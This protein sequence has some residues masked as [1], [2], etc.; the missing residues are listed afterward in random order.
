MQMDYGKKFTDQW[1]A[2]NSAAMASHWEYELDGYTPNEIQRGIIAMENKD[3]PP[4]LPEFKKM[5]RPPVD[6]M[7]AYYEALA[8]LEARGKGEAGTWSHPAI[9]WA[10]SSMR[11]DL[12]AQ[13]YAQIKDRWA[14]VLA[15]QMN[16]GAWADIPPPRVMLP[17]PDQSANARQHA[18]EMLRKLGAS[19]II[20]RQPGG[21]PKAWAKRILD[22]AAR[23]DKALLPIQ[24]KF[25]EM[26]L[27]EA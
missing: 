27:E 12:M 13:P 16:M 23:G 2:L 15:G 1:G 10:A 6:A 11:V 4:T 9:Y 14:T 25:A 7:P 26:A 17:A 24:I 21:D 22:R 3:W 8:G 18:Q 20:K 19:G 5:C